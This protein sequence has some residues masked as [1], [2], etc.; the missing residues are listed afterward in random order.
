MHCDTV[1]GNKIA[2]A[3]TGV[4][5]GSAGGLK[6]RRQKSQPLSEGSRNEVEAIFVHKSL[7]KGTIDL[8]SLLLP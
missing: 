4:L 5:H 6:N 2:K 3:L 7:L 8:L 1:Q